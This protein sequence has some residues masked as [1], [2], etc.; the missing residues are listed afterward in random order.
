VYPSNAVY[1]NVNAN[2]KVQANGRD[3]N[4]AHRIQAATPR[5]FKHRSNK[6]PRRSKFAKARGLAGLSL[7]PLDL[8]HTTSNHIV[9]VSL[10]SNF[11][12][13]DRGKKMV[14]NAAV[15]AG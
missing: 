12:D 1:A 11:Q 6:Q 15:V 8:C 9:S 2:V 14:A 10:N 7:A 4:S 5:L 3:G 13:L